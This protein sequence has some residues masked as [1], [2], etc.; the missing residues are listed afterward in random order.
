[1]IYGWDQ[2]ISATNGGVTALDDV[3]SHHVQVGSYTE[4][5]DALGISNY[6][7]SNIQYND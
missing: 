7:V 2:D 1:M 3:K 6:I 4:T 5:G